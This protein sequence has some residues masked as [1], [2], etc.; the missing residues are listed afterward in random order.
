MPR[1]IS[2]LP[3]LH[4]IERSVQNSVRSHYQ[5]RDLEQLFSLQPRARNS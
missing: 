3:Q 2:W 1:P 5:R 4:A